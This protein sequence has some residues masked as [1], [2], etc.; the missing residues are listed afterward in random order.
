MELITII[1]SFA[2]L[3]FLI[4]TT[5][6]MKGIRRKIIIIGYVLNVITISRICLNGIANKQNEET[7]Q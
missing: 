2:G 3:D 1:V 4:F 5:I 7:R 6:C